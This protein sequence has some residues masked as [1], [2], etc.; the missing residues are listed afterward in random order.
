MADAAA[1]ATKT[2]AAKPAED[3]AMPEC[4]VWQLTSA[5][6]PLTEPV[7]DG[8]TWEELGRTGAKCFKLEIEGKPEDDPEL[9]EIK[10]LGSFEWTGRAGL[11]PD[12]KPTTKQA[13]YFLETAEHFHTSEQL[14][15]VVSGCGY[16][17]I[18]LTEAAGG[19]A[20]GSEPTDW[21]RLKLESGD[22]I[23]LPEGAPRPC[24]SS[25]WPCPLPAPAPVGLLDELARDCRQP[26]DEMCRA[27]ARNLLP[28]PADRGPGHRIFGLE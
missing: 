2:P 13:G 1:A 10:R 23:Q 26:K 16:L 18:R 14:H 28:L 21:A 17:D 11:G 27:C 22:M 3:N 7:A 5:K 8:L 24:P 6:C 9:L 20:G 25:H 19:S 12:G 4:Q 15:Y